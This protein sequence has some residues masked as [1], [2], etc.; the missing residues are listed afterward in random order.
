M[1]ILV[2][3]PSCS[4]KFRAADAARG[5][6]VPCPECE[7]PLVLDGER[8]PN[9]DVF[10]SYSS[11]DKA[12]ADAACAALE[13]KR[14]RCW[15]APRDVLPGKT[16]ASSIIDAI[17]DARVMVL[18][19]S[20]NANVSEQ[21]LREVE[22]AVAKG[23]HVVTFRVAAADLSKDLEYFLSASHWL[24][25]VQ[26]PIGD[27]LADLATKVKALLKEPGSP[28]VG[29]AVAGPTTGKRSRVPAWAM[30]IAATAVAAVTLTIVWNRERPNASGLASA[31]APTTTAAAA[32]RPAGP[33]GL[34][35]RKE[36]QDHVILPT[37]RYGGGHSI[38]VEAFAMAGDGGHTLVG[39]QQWGGLGLTH[40]GGL[41]RMVSHDRTGYRFASSDKPAVPGDLVHLAGVYDV[42]RS[43]L[44]LYV[45]GRRQSTT[46]GVNGHRASPLPFLIG[47]NPSNRLTAEYSFSGAVRSVRFSKFARY[48]GDFAPPPHEMEAD[49]MTIGLYRLEEGGGRVA[50]DASGND[51]D[52]IVHGAEW[53]LE[54]RPDAAPA[55]RPL[56]S[57]AH[58]RE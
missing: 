40:E 21:V 31:G 4:N 27:R 24:D 5:A 29:G 7:H 2:R 3:C 25:A 55:S 46:R 28:R 51:H 16:W 41:W 12:I 15:I 54:D 50:H 48:T 1:A 18:V 8:V 19:F 26:G 33:P 36:R 10:I 30:G 6:G 37:L 23:V 22:R 9:N 42:D 57:A 44:R 52:G 11:K 47:G 17:A 20:P 56:L 58:R 39:N 14:V 38:T 34:R 32:T 43:E 35:F 13:A 49:A 45:N 53:G